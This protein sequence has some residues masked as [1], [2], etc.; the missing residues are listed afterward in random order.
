MYLHYGI[1]IIRDRGID[2][3]ALEMIE[4]RHGPRGIVFVD[5]WTRKGA[6]I[7]ERARVYGLLNEQNVEGIRRLT[8]TQLK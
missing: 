4:R 3:T 5:G 2:T 6:M 8:A 1:S 7:L